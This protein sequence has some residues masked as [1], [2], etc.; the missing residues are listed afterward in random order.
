MVGATDVLS[1]T[2][3]TNDNHNGN[4]NKCNKEPEA[5]PPPL[6]AALGRAQSTVSLLATSL[7]FLLGL[8]CMILDNIE[9]LVLLLDEDGHCL[10]YTSDA[11][12]E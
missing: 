5:N 8:H 6:A 10:L 9:L 3:S 11:A 12:D 7:H 1:T 2:D 4:N